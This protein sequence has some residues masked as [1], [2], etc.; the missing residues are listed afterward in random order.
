M[1]DFEYLFK[2]KKCKEEL[3]YQCN[4]FSDFK[5]YTYIYNC[6]CNLEYC[7]KYYNGFIEKNNLLI[8]IIEFL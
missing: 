7:E 4:T 1:N 5:V 2:S 6:T 8:K 3:K